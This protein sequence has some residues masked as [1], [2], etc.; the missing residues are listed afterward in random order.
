MKKVFAILCLSAVILF[1][2]CAKKNTATKTTVT[3]TTSY[4]GEVFPLIQVKC[5]PCHLPSKGGNKTSF[6][7]YESTKKHAAEI[8][9]RIELEPGQRGFMP[10]K[11][12]KLSADEIAVFKNW[13]ESGSAEK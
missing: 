1:A 7:N 8:L 11:H 12:D 6:E 3:S 9:R 10:M 2:A 4:A 13:V 5:S